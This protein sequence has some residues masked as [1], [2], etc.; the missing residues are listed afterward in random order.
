MQ[1]PLQSSELSERQS[2]PP[3]RLERLRG[4]A[5]LILLS[6]KTPYFVWGLAA[7][8]RVREYFY[9]R[10]L[11]LDEAHVVLKVLAPN[12]WEVIASGNWNQTLPVGMAVVMRVL[13]GV[14]GDS[15]Y[16]L[17]LMPLL[18]SL[19]S[20]PL[21]YRIS[22]EYLK[23][24]LVPLALLLFSV[25]PP[26]VYYAAEA[27]HYSSDVFVCL[28]L[29]VLALEV[30]RS[31]FKTKTWVLGVAA[32]ASTWFSFTSVFVSLGIAVAFG[33]QTLRAGRPERLA[34]GVPWITCW[35]LSLGFHYYASLRYLVSNPTLHRQWVSWGGF[36]PATY[37]SLAWAKWFV[38]VWFGRLPSTFGI[39]YGYFA[40]AFASFGAWLLLRR[41]RPK[42]YLILMPMVFLI[43]AAAAGYYP[44]LTRV[45]LFAAPLYLLALIQGIGSAME[46]RP[47]K[48]LG[49]G[50]T[51]VLSGQLFLGATYNFVHPSV[52][53]H[54]RPLLTHLREKQQPEDLV[55]VSQYAKDAFNY[56]VRRHPLVGPVSIGISCRDVPLEVCEKDFLRRVVGRERLWVLLSHVMPEEKDRLVHIA[57]RWGERASTVESGDT[58]LLLYRFKQREL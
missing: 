35:A 8:L 4:S 15:E 32:C 49:W 44:V 45:A 7:T 51:A 14:I 1:S 46:L 41:L 10:S 39:S 28:L 16:V 57:D 56:S 13:V 24:Q 3:D 58:T 25:A 17:R 21:F 18:C 42:S 9:N 29:L 52:R 43:L 23:P 2:T 36:G 33:A 55:Y 30:M 11:W 26:L 48:F 50:A 31:D 20:F 6:A 34:K 37:D 40:S 54:I 12:F 27:K 38:S 5:N 47:L 53:E 19:L 22:R